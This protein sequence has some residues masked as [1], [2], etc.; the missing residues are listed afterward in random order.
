M[1]GKSSKNKNNHTNTAESVVKTFCV[2]TTKQPSRN[3]RKKFACPEKLRD[4]LERMNL[5]DPKPRLIEWNEA[6][7]LTR[8][9]YPHLQGYDFLQASF[10]RC[11]EDL[12]KELKTFVSTGKLVPTVVD[13]SFNNSIVVQIQ[14]YEDFRLSSLKLIRLAHLAKHFGDS[15]ALRVISED[16]ASTYVLRVDEN[17][18]VYASD[19]FL[20]VIN[21]VML[22]RIRCCEICERVFWAYRKD[23]FTCSPKHSDIRRKRKSYN[24]IKKKRTKELDLINAKRRENDDYKKRLKRGKSK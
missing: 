21:G 12:P 6:Q 16:F 22:D 1:H 7:L 17:G 11:L 9:H 20:E 19:S 2:K 23:S 10:A 14:R 8:S 18:I 24:N 4:L 13:S 15:H 3:S 5:L